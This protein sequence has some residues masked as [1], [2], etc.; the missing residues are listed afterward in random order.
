[1]KDSNKRFKCRIKRVRRSI[2]GTNIVPRLSV[3]RGSRHIYAQIIDDNKGFTIVS[4]STL[5]YKF[6]SGYNISTNSIAAAEIIG[7]LIAKKAFDRGIKKVVFDRR[8][9][10]YIG[11]IKSL[12][13][14]VRKFGIKF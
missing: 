2:Y 4:E 6:K 9:Y 5:S 10:R 13:D 7:G 1:M 11:K 3:Y 12:A 14:A 8:G